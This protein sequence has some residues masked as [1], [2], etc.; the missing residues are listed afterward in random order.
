MKKTI[1]LFL[2][3]LVYIS[4]FAQ[5]DAEFYYKMEDSGYLVNPRFANEGI[6]VTDNLHSTLYLIKSK[7]LIK[8]FSSPDC[9][10]YYEISPDGT[11]IGFKYIEPKTGKQA[12]A[13]FDIKTRKLRLLHEPVELAG[14]V[15]FTNQN[16]IA[17]TIGNYLHFHNNNNVRKYNL[18]N[19]SNI[20]PISPD[21]KYVFFQTKSE[22]ICLFELN[23][24]KRTIITNKAGYYAGSWSDDS[25][26]IL[27]YDYRGKFYVYNIP[28]DHLYFHKY[29]GNAVWQADSKH[30]IFSHKKTKSFKLT[31]AELYIT[32]FSGKTI[33]KLTDTNNY[34][35]MTPDYQNNKIVFYNYFDKSIA[36]YRFKKD[37]LF[38]FKK[39]Y[40]LEDKLDLNYFNL[41]IDDNNKNNLDI[42][43]IHQVYDTEDG[44]SHKYGCCAAATAS[45]AIMYYKIFPHWD[46][47]ASSPYSHTSH[48]GKY[49]GDIYKYRSYTYDDPAYSGGI[50]SYHWSSGSPNSKMRQLLENHG[51]TSAQ[52]WTTNCTYSRI[53]SDVEEGYPYL[54]CVM[55]TTSGHLIL[56]K[57]IYDDAK[58]LLY[59]NDPYGNQNSSPYLGYDG[60]DV[61][62]DWPGES[63]G[64]ACLDTIAWS[65]SAEAIQQAKP[66]LN[67]D[68]LQ[69]AYNDYED[70][71]ASNIGFYLYTGGTGGMRYWRGELG[72]YNNNFWWTGAMS[73]TTDDYYASWRPQIDS[74][75]IYEVKVYLP[76]TTTVTTNARYQIYHNNGNDLVTINQSA[77]VGSW[78]SLGT[79]T[80]NSDDSGYLY[81]GDATGSKDAPARK[82]SAKATKVLFDAVKFIPQTSANDIAIYYSDFE[83]NDGGLFAGGEWDWGNDSTAGAASGSNVWGTLLNGNYTDGANY[84]LDL[85]VTLPDTCILEF[86]HWYDIESTKREVV[87][88]GGNVKISNNGGSSFTVISP[89]S[90]YP[91]TINSAHSNP[92]GGEL[93]FAGISSG[94]EHLTFDLSSYANADVIIRWNF[95]SDGAT[96]DHGWYI[97]NVSIKELADGSGIANN[98]NDPTQPVSIDVQSIVIDGSTVDPDMSVVDNLGIQPLQ[99]EVT[100]SAQTQQYSV[101]NESN[102]L[103]SYYPLITGNIQNVQLNFD[104]SYSGLNYNGTHPAYLKWYNTSTSSWE[105]VPSPSWN[106]GTENVN[107][108]LTLE[109]TKDGHTEFIMGDD[110]PLPV[111]LSAFTSTYSN[112]LPMLSWSTLSENQNSHWNVYRALSSN[113]GQAE[114]INNQSIPGQGTS[115]NQH[116][117]SYVD[118]NEV[119]AQTA[120]YYWL[121]SVN[122]SGG[123]ELYGCIELI[124]P[125]EHNQPASPEIPHRYGLYENFP[126]P[127]NPDTKI[128][129]AVKKDCKATITIYN[130]KGEKVKTLLENHPVARDR[131]IRVDWNGR[132]HLDKPVASGVYFYKLKAGNVNQLRKML[133]MK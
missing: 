121:E 74:T 60:D 105:D 72:G 67:I 89:E 5:K 130:L 75:G 30:I 82:G 71:S 10:S 40:Q 70:Y 29:T 118:E 129:F 123:T 79:Y 38:D 68:D 20:S 109:N 93:G 45:M 28:E 52:H 104:L 4:A 59:Y 102:V 47:T 18:G 116:N 17:F 22:K 21:G 16:K 117:Y 80:F 127:F 84:K 113:F 12:P 24:K 120:Y 94:W 9:G 61:I 57:G 26:K 53:S 101:P 111:S 11:K 50:D 107:F 126:N 44:Y 43:Y 58:K 14:Q 13:I 100:T 106:T 83:D 128:S 103:I 23:S 1:I 97:D 115:T 31:S 48:W 95:G 133:L 3:I 110:D 25:Q 39:L 63:N 51:L 122:F 119:N 73:G 81:L 37:K 19:F 91:D 2:F 125:E 41:K 33:N 7:K 66:Q 34:Y 124:I 65:V 78:V 77:N 114:K 131:I 46:V 62:Y 32:D 98:H 42:P 86:D 76:D 87:Y 54:L 132:N 90:S 35:E 56:A 92:L 64:Y 69:L 55:L 8:L 99:I 88:D 36:L 85:A 6:I 112:G 108:S 27:F 96:T 15:S 49:I